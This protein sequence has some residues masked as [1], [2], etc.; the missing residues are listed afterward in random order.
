VVFEAAVAVDAESDY[1]GQITV[2]GLRP[3]TPHRAIVRFTDEA[4][5]TGSPEA[6]V[7]RTAP[8]ARDPASVRLAWGGDLGGQGVCR[9]A[10]RGYPI[11]ERILAEQPD[12][13]VA[14]GDMIYAD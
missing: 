8:R 11:F 9:D 12:L 6:A 10:R 2:E 14:L 5:R 4:G 3:A 1:T 13:F 7:F